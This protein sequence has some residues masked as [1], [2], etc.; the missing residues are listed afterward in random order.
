MLTNDSTSAK[1]IQLRF[2]DMAAGAHTHVELLL[3]RHGVATWRRRRLGAPTVGVECDPPPRPALLNPLLR[4]TFS[5]DLPVDEV[6]AETGPLVAARRWM[7]WRLLGSI[8]QS[9]KN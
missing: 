8:H 2:R 9:T 6:A 7:P 1:I 5:L 4:P 3:A